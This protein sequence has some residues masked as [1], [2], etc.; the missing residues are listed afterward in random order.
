MVISTT[1]MFGFSLDA[2][3]TIFITCVVFYYML[4][5]TGASGENIGLAVS[6]AINL[7]GLVPWGETH[8]S[9]LLTMKK[10]INISI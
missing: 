2:M 8:F 9:D 6:Q 10:H 7:T 4:L 5:D 1:S 3:C